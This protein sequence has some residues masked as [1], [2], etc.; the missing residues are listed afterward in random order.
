[1]LYFAPFIL[2]FLF[3]AAFLVCV[4]FLFHAFPRFA[5]IFRQPLGGR[6][7]GRRNSIRIGGV[8]IA[9]GFFAAIF[10]HGALVIDDRTM[11]FL[12]GL[13]VITLWGFLDDLFGLSW[14]LQLLLQA[15]TALLV[16]IAGIAILGMSTPVG[17]VDFASGGMLFSSLSMIVTVVWIVGMMNVLNWSDGVD[18]LSG[19]VT[20]IASATLL[21]IALRPEVFQP[22]V[23]VLASAVCG[24]VLAF[25]L[26][27]VVTGRV[28]AG[29]S[30]SYFMG[31]VL[32]VLA[33]FAGA[34]IG[35]ALLVLIVPIVDAL[36]VLLSRARARA[37][38]FVGDT[39]HFHHHLLARGFRV[40]QILL[41]Y[42]SLTVLGALAALSTQSL[43]KMFVLALYAS[44]IFLVIILLRYQ[45]SYE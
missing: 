38:L 1:M 7:V 8:A 45:K 4:G 37:S 22:P 31:F 24:S 6:H 20:F 42:Y 40:W 32:A 14:W 26:L 10:F 5:R 3:C 12:L 18:G 39:R 2:S 25:T 15:V 21:V 23:A 17:W 29:S 19:G 13:L 33:I 35:T 41:L 44:V 9:C 30:G 27:N 34:K 43:G 28:I 36:C 16:A 11:I